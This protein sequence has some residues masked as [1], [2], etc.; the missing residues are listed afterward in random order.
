MAPELVAPE[1]ALFTMALGLTPPWQVV[2][3]NF[4]KEAHEL[5]LYVDFPQGNRFAC[6]ECEASCSVYDSDPDRLWRHL[7]FFEHKTFLHAR[8]PRVACP[9]CGV[10]TVP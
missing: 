4:D 2:Q 7:N 8:L 3:V 10:K 1:L 9:H 5:H 6:P